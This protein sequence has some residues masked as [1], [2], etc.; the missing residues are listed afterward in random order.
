MN[1]VV[2]KRTLN[3]GALEGREVQLTFS[4]TFTEKTLLFHILWDLNVKVSAEGVP[5]FSGA[6]TKTAAVNISVTVCNPDN[7]VFL[8]LIA[9]LIFET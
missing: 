4:T 8:K 1:T 6:T 7:S 5:L 2:L 9:V 3:K